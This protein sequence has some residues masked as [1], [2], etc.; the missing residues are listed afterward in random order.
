MTRLSQEQK[1]LNL[2]QGFPDFAGPSYLIERIHA[3]LDSC[4]N[5]YTRAYGHP[6]LCEALHAYSARS[7]PRSYDALEEIT[8]VNGATEGICCT[9][10]GLVEPGKKVLVFEPYYESYAG[11]AKIAG[12]E[13]AGVPLLPPVNTKELDQGLWSIDWEQFDEAMKNNV[14]IVM[15]NHPHNPTGKVFNEEELRRIFS[16]AE[17]QGIPVA[18]DGVY[19]NLVYATGPKNFMPFLAR[20]SENI[21]YISSIS[22]S[23]SFTGFKIGWVFA[24]KAYMRAI[25]AV[26]EAAVY[27]QPPHLQLAVADMINNHKHFDDYV[28]QL[29][30][31]FL[32]IRDDMR[33]ALTDFGFSVPNAQ[34][35]YF[36]LAQK[37]EAPLKTLSDQEMAFELLEQYRIAT[38][39]V[40]GFYVGEPLL[41][42]WLRFAFCKRPETITAFKKALGQNVL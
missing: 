33:S 22:K 34:G 28:N 1:A 38:I 4:P 7:L 16:C 41:K 30:R 40:S 42:D 3:H 15:L 21:I 18:I 23:L 9:I 27:C 26:H 35:T 10:V 31:D 11:C 36:L 29:R 12:L 8:V 6:R 2:A 39:P 19:E 5:Q 20:Y 32:H 24:P 25:R 17:K 14:G 37:N 13:L